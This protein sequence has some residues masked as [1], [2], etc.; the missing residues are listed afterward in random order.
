MEEIL[1]EMKNA[2]RHRAQVKAC[3]TLT[4]HTIIASFAVLVSARR[5]AEQL[6][7]LTS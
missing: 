6:K 7:F 4:R 2:A 3:Y 1:P 5:P